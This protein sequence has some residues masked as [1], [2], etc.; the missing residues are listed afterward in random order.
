MPQKNPPELAEEIGREVGMNRVGV[1]SRRNAQRIVARG[2]IPFPA[3]QPDKEEAR[4]HPT[5][6]RVAL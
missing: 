5:T 2:P 1:P 4:S 6:T 3:D